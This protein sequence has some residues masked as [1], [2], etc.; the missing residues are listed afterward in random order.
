MCIRDRVI[1]VVV[2]VVMVV[3]VMMVVLVMTHCGG[4]LNEFDQDQMVYK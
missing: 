4:G 2:M 3:E 1:V